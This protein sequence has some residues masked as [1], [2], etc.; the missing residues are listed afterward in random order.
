M[1]ESTVDFAYFVHGSCYDNG[2]WV[3]AYLPVQNISFQGMQMP[4]QL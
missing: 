3:E 1:D 4:H 2:S